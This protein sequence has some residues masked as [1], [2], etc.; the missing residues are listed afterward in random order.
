MLVTSRERAPELALAGT[1]MGFDL[2]T[3]FKPTETA[4]VSQPIAEVKAEEA[5]TSAFNWGELIGNIGKAVDVGMDIWKG[6]TNQ[7]VQ[8]AQLELAKVNADTAGQRARADQLIAETRRIQAERRTLVPAAAGV[9]GI[10][11]LGLGAAAVYFLTRRK[12]R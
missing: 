9:G 11:L 3:L 12:R 10:A 6:A 5:E 1:R 8:V 7:D 4:L 2:T